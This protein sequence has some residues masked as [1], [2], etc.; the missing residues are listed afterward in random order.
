MLSRWL[1]YGVIGGAWL[2][3]LVVG[4]CTTT[5]NYS[6]P[7][8]DH[9]KVS[10]GQSESVKEINSNTDPTNKTPFLYVPSSDALAQLGSW[11]QDNRFWLT[12]WM[13]RYPL[14]S[15]ADPMRF[16]NSGLRSDLFQLIVYTQLNNNDVKI[17]QINLSKQLAVLGVAKAQSNLGVGASVDRKWTRSGGAVQNAYN[18][19]I[20]LNYDLDLW[21]QLSDD[22]KA[23]QST[24]D[25]VQ[26]DLKRIK[27]TMISAV[28]KTYWAL[29][30]ELAIFKLQ[31][32]LLRHEQKQLELIQKRQQLGMDT[33]AEVEE[34]AVRYQQAVLDKE[35]TK[36]NI[37]MYERVLAGLLGQPVGTQFNI[38]PVEL[39]ELDY[40]PVLPADL[41]SNLVFYR[42]DVA[43]AEQRLKASFYQNAALKKQ[44]LPS[45]SLT[46]ALGTVSEQLKNVLT[47]PIQTLGMGLSLPLLQ[48]GEI[49]QSIRVSELAYEA[50]VEN[51]RQ[52][53]QQA[54]RDTF[55]T[56]E[57]FD[58]S[59]KTLSIQKQSVL[60]S[61]ELDR[62]AK[63]KYQLGTLSELDYLEMQ[64]ALITQKI[65]WL[66][67]RQMV[68]EDFASVYEVLG[69]AVIDPSTVQ[70]QQ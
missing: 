34:M 69:G 12:A 29:A 11:P 21:G 63:L 41:S 4:A 16:S 43:A 20:R 55:D 42:P 46:A 18:T 59:K 64:Q 2:S 13:G 15:S 57:R 40:A 26:E 5:A 33:Q 27:L 7:D 31:D 39:N 51:F 58:L 10:L 52:V 47:N 65:V 48:W 44:F 28:V 25:A 67:S 9:P 19:S 22:E 1:K 50:N 8:I 54:Y 36:Q 49:K 37:H 62:Q 24:V 60:S 56:L 14:S 61:L 66:K 32:D 3:L 38:D 35:Q 53:V 68:L 6:R 45:F 70:A 17:A 30:T 23:A